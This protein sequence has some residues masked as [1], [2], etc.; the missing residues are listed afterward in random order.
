LARLIKRGPIEL[1]S[2]ESVDALIPAR[3][4]V[5]IEGRSSLPNF[6]PQLYAQEKP[7]ARRVQA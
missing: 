6:L 1:V 4:E 5:A 3:A 2:A 7:Q